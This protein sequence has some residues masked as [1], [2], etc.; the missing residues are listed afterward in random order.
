[1]R[2][3]RETHYNKQGRRKRSGGNEI[4]VYPSMRLLRRNLQM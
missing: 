2:I 3:S 1:M 4:Q